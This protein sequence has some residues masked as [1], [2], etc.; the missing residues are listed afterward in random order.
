MTGLARPQRTTRF[1]RPVKTIAYIEALES[2]PYDEL[3]PARSLIEL[4][5]ATA[6]FHADRP[7]ITTVP[8]GT[9]PA[10][11]QR[12][13]IATFISGSF[14]RQ[15]C[16]TTFSKH[17]AAGRSLS[18]PIVEGMMEALLGAIPQASL[19]TINYLSPPM[20][21]PICRRPRARPFWFLSLSRLTLQCGRRP[22]LL[23]NGQSR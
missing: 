19:S 2:R 14:A 17:R 13:R 11:S 3:I 18:G 4:L 22:K 12:S 16:F 8:G 20:S 7:A 6:H 15:I 9:S 10:T 1:T 23:L 5:Y 21:S